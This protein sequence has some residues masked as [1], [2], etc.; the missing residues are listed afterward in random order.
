LARVSAI[1]WSS[2]SEINGDTTN[3][4]PFSEAFENTAGLNVI[5]TN[6]VEEVIMIGFITLTLCRKIGSLKKLYQTVRERVYILEVVISSCIN[7]SED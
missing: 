2:I 6:S 1:T 4:K 3:V 7:Q 5:F